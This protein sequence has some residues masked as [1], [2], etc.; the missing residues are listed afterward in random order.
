MTDTKTNNM[1][2]LKVTSVRYFE[3]RRGIGYECN[4]NI[5]TVQIWNDGNGGG[6]FIAPCIAAREMNL[7]K[8]SE[9]ELESLIDKYENVNQ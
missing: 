4:T 5:P 2:D 7:Y 9:S 3:T 6:T 8:I 1:T